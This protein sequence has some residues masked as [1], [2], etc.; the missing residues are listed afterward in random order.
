SCLVEDKTQRL[1]IL[2]VYLSETDEIDRLVYHFLFCF[3][4]CF[5]INDLCS[6]ISR[7]LE[8]C[9]LFPVCLSTFLIIIIVG[10]IDSAVVEGLSM[11]TCGVSSQCR[12]PLCDK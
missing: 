9:C 2:P 8:R 7:N 4:I 5:V 1:I 3:A 6:S 10:A 12:Y 11:V